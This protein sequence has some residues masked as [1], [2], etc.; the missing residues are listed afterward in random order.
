MSFL[1]PKPP[2]APDYN[3]LA[4][5]QGQINA[6][7]ARQVAQMNRPN[8]ITP[9]G[10][11]NW[12]VNPN[13]PNQWTMTETLSPEE[14]QKLD[15]QNALQMMMLGGVTEYG[16]PQLFNA[17]NTSM[18]PPRE[19]QLGWENA[20]APDQRLQTESGM[21]NAP[22]I[23]EMLD[24]SNA[25]AL[26]SSLNLSGV[27]GIPQA[28]EAYRK[29]MADTL[30]GMGA[31]YLDPQFQKAHDRLDTKLS[32]Q[33]IFVGSDAFK[34]SQDVLADQEART[35]GDL[36]DRAIAQS[37][38]EMANL[39]GLQ[40]QGH[41]TGFQDQQTLASLNN[42]ARAQ[43]TGEQAQQGAFA[44]S[45]RSQ[46]INELLQDMQAR[47]AAITGQANMAGAQ[48]N[49]SNTGTQAWLSQK[50]QATT[51][52]INMMTAIMSGSQVN[53]PQWQPYNNNISYQPAN[54]Y[55]A[56]QDQYGAAMNNANFQQGQIGNWLNFGSAFL[57]KGK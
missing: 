44:N 31:R 29:Q 4:I 10:T 16:L 5:Q 37:G 15:M 41:N 53:N 19:A 13:D 52:P 14:Q 1:F 50:A 51:M 38:Q 34:D 27:Q 42:A 49:A 55:Q 35:Y 39:F 36:R 54:V 24:F 30:Y 17:L 3:A 40:M 47:N 48:Q 12:T 45:A 2:P 26:Q 20:Y 33:G 21:Y 32:N 43:Y 22:W 56:G 46:L 28:D 7:T 18:T 25:P 57:P 8:E 11:R 6:D 23:Q 9:Y